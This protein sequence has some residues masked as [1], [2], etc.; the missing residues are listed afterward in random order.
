M[1]VYEGGMC[2]Y[3]AVAKFFFKNAYFDPK[4]EEMRKKNFV[5]G[6]DILHITLLAQGKF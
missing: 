1:T 4:H 6:G 5:T 3:Q 2:R